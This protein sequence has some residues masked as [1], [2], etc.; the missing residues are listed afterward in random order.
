M[1]SG[2]ARSLVAVTSDMQGSEVLEKL[3]TTDRFAPLR[4]PPTS[5]KLSQAPTIAESVGRSLIGAEHMP[6]SGDSAMEDSDSSDDYDTDETDPEDVR[7]YIR[8]MQQEATHAANNAPVL[9][10]RGRGPPS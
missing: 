10:E 6:N 8:E 2:S 5:S 1:S 9:V 4:P 7:D 3:L